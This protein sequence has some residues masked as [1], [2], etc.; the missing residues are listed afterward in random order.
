MYP[1]CEMSSCTMA[2]TSMEFVAVLAAHPGTAHVTCAAVWARPARSLV[3]PLKDAA[4]GLWSAYSVRVMGVVDSDCVGTNL[5]VNVMIVLACGVISWIDENAV[6]S[7][8]G[9]THWR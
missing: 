4:E 6:Q 1:G 7:R 2:D 9:C 8:G 3:P 5:Q